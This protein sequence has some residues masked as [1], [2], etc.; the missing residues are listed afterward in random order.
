MIP[1]YVNLV[2]CRVRQKQFN[3]T[4]FYPRY[5][6]GMYNTAMVLTPTLTFVIGKIWCLYIMFN[7]N[8]K[9]VIFPISK[10]SSISLSVAETSQQIIVEATHMGRHIS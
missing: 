1:W 9:V 2:I 5:R 4:G 7:H 8:W 3:H 6:F 10:F